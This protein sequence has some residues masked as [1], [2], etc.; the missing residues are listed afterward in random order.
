MLMD[1]MLD[2]EYTGIVRLN[3]MW[4]IIF[5]SIEWTL[6]NPSPSCIL[7]PY[8]SRVCVYLSTRLE[9]QNLLTLHLNSFTA[10]TLFLFLKIAYK[11]YRHFLGLADF[12]YLESS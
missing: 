6:S 8:V 2:M 9:N 11:A 1:S 5:T 7:F 4:S 3:Y 10:R 12:V